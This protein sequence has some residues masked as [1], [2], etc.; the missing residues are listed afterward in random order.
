MYHLFKTY[1]HSLWTFFFVGD[2]LTNHSKMP[3]SVK[4]NL[5][6]LKQFWAGLYTN[7]KKFLMKNANFTSYL[8][9]ES[10][11]VFSIP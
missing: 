3:I 11:A 8:S 9:G 2:G 7:Y 1:A 5:S 4:K 10:N 6:Q